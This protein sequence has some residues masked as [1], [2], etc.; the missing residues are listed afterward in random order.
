MKSLIDS[1]SSVKLAIFLLIIIT[2]A[3]ILGTLIPQQRS[4]AEYMAK[5][6]QISKLYI[7]FQFTDVYHSLWYKAFL[8]L[9]AINTVVCT[10]T[11]IS[12][13]WTR[14]FKAS[15]ERDKQ[16]ILDL[17]IQDNFFKKGNLETTRNEVIRVLA[18]KRFRV[19]E[20]QR[21]NRVSL[22]GR[23]KILGIFGS[24]IVHLGILII[25]LGGIISG[26]GDRQMLTI[27]EGQVVSIPGAEFQ[28]RLD[29]FETDYYA[30]G[31]V[32]D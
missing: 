7:R 15:V 29:K 12:P 16:R 31:S 2:L 19:K 26:R 8:L 13:K 30:N 21:E 1:F 18:S 28:L 3:S 32:K 24:D 27:L 5:Y 10:L 4:P 20:S 14:A 22:W 9:F 23:K 17:K 6:G 11:R 25:L